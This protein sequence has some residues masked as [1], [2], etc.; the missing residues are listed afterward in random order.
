MT[1]KRWRLAGAAAY[2]AAGIALP[3]LAGAL[4]GQSAMPMVMNVLI[5]VAAYAIAA[6]GLNMIVGYCGLL[7]LGFGGFMLI[8]AYTA[9]ILMKEQGFSFWAA[10]PAAAA[11]AALWGIILGIPTLRLTGD[12]FAI[13][14]FGF[15]ELVVMVAQNW[16]AVTRGTRGYPGVPR[17]VLDLPGT[18]F[19]I[20]FTLD[21]KTA[22]WYL[23]ASLLGV[24]M[25]VVSRLSRSRLGRAWRALREDEVAAE[26]CGIN[27]QWHRTVAFAISAGFGGLAG[28]LLASYA[29]FVDYRQ[30]TFMTSVFVL[31]YIVLGGMGTVIGPVVG[32][33]VL[34][35]LGEVLRDNPASY[36]GLRDMPWDPA[37]RFL[38]YGVILILVIR[39]RPEGLFPSRSRSRELHG[40]TE[41]A[42]GEPDTLFDLRQ[43]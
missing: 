19:D 20:A 39:Y 30:F 26:A 12:Y 13:V 11:H 35:S 4:L 17:P 14:T 32:A 27:A 3:H 31:C 15:S 38:L 34:V 42:A 16:V 5:L 29:A 23:A 28:A 41:G 36:F 33:A 6:L 25:V 8:G 18:R 22:Y 40:R 43:E 2:I 10:A 1:P 24:C 37:M 21:A 7:N 9:A